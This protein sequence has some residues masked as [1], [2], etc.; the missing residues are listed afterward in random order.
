MHKL[1]TNICSV[2]HATLK[3]P[4]IVR[5]NNVLEPTLI[6]IMRINVGNIST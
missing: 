4:N 1:P 3:C 5:H 6:F 2:T